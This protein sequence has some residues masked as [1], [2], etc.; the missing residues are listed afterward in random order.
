MSTSIRF[1]GQALPKYPI[2]DDENAKDYLYKLC[3]QG[4]KKR[5]STISKELEERLTYELSIIDE[6]QFNDY[7]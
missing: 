6:M 7:F 5:Y 1:G 4:L 2:S 3:F